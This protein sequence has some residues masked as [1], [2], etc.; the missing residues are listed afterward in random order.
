MKVS[1]RKANAIQL[2]INE[3]I[4]APLFSTVSINK[5]DEPLS[6][7][8]EAADKL[9][10]AIDQKSELI[11][12]LYYIRRSVANAGHDAGIADLLTEQALIS[13]KEQIFRELALTSKFASTKET[14][15]AQLAELKAP[16]IAGG[17][18][19]PTFEVGLLNKDTIESYRK[20]TVTLRKE[21]QKINDKLL[22]LNVTTEIDLPAGIENV[23]KKYEII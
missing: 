6:V 13:K 19:A 10:A 18:R 4:N 3:Q 1:L 20:A 21:K 16:V 14:L 17:Y 22:H 15:D 5:F 2:L 11:G 9:L 12:T 7:E 23:L 8:T